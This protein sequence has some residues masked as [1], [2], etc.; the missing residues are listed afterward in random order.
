MPYVPTTWIDRAVATPN[1]YTKSDET[2]TEVTLIQEPGT[3]TQSGTPLNA[4]NLNKIETNLQTT[5][6]AS[7]AHIATQTTVHGSTSAATAN[8]LVHRDASGRAQFADP[9][10]AADAATKSYVDSVVTV[11]TYTGNGATART[12]SL[13]KTPKCVII[14]GNTTYN[15][16]AANMKYET[17]HTTKGYVFGTASSFD[18]VNVQ[19]N[20]PRITTN[21]F[22]V[23]TAD[24]NNDLANKN[25]IVFDYIA[26]Y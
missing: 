26:Y 19:V 1:K 6:D 16:V 14:R 11:G 17:Q 3:I 23:D 12:I 8:K 15:N 25:T 21:G 20:Y 7:E 13:P 9:S 18:Y 4:T 22:I 10:A 5:F 2:S 24:V